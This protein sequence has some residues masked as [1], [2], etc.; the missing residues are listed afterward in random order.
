MPLD[1]NQGLFCCDC[2][3]ET[4]TQLT[5][6]LTPELRDTYQEVFAPKFGRQLTRDEITEIACNL[7]DFAE[8]YLK[9][10]WRLK[11]DPKTKEESGVSQ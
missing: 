2:V 6:W 3:K 4:I 8:L 7:A 5:S 9:F 1:C 11:N 10:R